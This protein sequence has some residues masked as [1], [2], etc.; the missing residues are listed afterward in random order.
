MDLDQEIHSVTLWY[1]LAVIWILAVP[2]MVC[3]SLDEQTHCGGK[4]QT[5]VE[6]GVKPEQL[7]LYV[8][9]CAKPNLV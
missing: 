4:P 1:C 3:P 7:W 9:Y 8:L 2:D 6:Y 5:T